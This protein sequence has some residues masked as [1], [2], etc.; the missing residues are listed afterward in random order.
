M[1]KQ[2]KPARG[3]LTGKSMID[4]KGEQDNNTALGGMDKQLT[5]MD[6]D[7][8]VMRMERIESKKQLE[9][10]FQDISRKI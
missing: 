4:Y 5:Q 2:D 3:K 8:E 1:E 10:K 6:R 9:A 7:Y